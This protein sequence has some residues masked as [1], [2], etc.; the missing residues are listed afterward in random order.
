MQWRVFV[1]RR[2]CARRCLDRYLR[3]HRSHLLQHAWNVWQRRS[4]QQRQLL[5]QLTQT[6]ERRRAREQA[7]QLRLRMVLL[8]LGELTKRVFLKVRT[9][10]TYLV[11]L[12]KYQFKWFCSFMRKI[13]VE[14]AGEGN[15]TGPLTAASCHS[16]YHPRATPTRIPCV[17]KA[18][19]SAS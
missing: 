14:V 4:A 11:Q 15:A 7:L 18:Y 17:G 9:C 13:S 5:V 16:S 12:S 19:C 6:E 10:R 8:G 2:A 3:Q 1:E